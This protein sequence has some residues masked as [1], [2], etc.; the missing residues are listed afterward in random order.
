M[1]IWL[2]RINIPSKVDNLKT[3]TFQYYSYS[4]IYIETRI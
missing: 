1:N 4:M 2:Y 3:N